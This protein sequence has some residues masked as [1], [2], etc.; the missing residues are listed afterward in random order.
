MNLKPLTFTPTLFYEYATCC[1]WIWHDRFSDPK[2]KGAMP[3]LSLKLFEQGVL[4]EKEYVKDLT[5]TQVKQVNL[6]QAFKETLPLM[7]AGV[8]LIYQGVIQYEADRVLYQGRPD[9][10]KKM[11]GKSKFGGYYYEPIEIKSTKELHTEQKYQLVFYG[12]V[13]EQIQGVFPAQAAIIN[14]DKKT[15]PFLMDSEQRT[16]T[17]AHMEIILD[18]IKGNKPPLKLVSSCKQSPWFNKCVSEAEA[19]NDIALLYRLDS[20]SH[21]ALRQNGINTVADAAKMDVDALPKIP[22]ATK[23]VLQRVKLQAQSLAEGKLIWLS[24]PELPD[25]KLKIFFDIE[26]DPLLQTQYLFG[27][28]IAGDP[29]FKYAKAEHV[30][31]NKADNRYFLYFL[32]KDPSEEEA[33]W[34]QFLQWLEVLPDDDYAVFH[35]ANYE[36]SWTKKLADKYGGSEKFRQFHSRLFDLENARK[37]SVIF[38]LYFYSIK[39]IAKSKFVDFHWRHAKAGGAQSVFWYEQWLENVDC[40]L[41]NDIIDYNEDDVR[42]TECFYFWLKQFAEGQKSWEIFTKKLPAAVPS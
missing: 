4:H 5:Y 23:E 30:R 25:P 19:A 38:P 40:D 36:N 7:Q 29:E 10:L 2:D 18:I 32:A 3:E 12:L 15:V 35:Y 20:R 8:E 21:P 26:G 34:K 9:L 37:E 6:A 31:K 39:D 1:H 24:K 13:L 41:L 22:F 11:P 27:F 33:L 16:K 17:I 14:H 42:A 28:W